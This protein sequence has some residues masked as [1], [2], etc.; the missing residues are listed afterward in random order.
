M[1]PNAREAL[2]TLLTDRTEEPP[3]ELLFWILV[4][5]GL[6]GGETATESDG[7]IAVG[8]PP[9]F[10]ALRGAR[11]QLD[12]AQFAKLTLS[13]GQIRWRTKGDT[14]LALNFLPD[15]LW[16]MILLV[17]GLSRCPWS[18]FSGQLGWSLK[19]YIGLAAVLVRAAYVYG[20][21][22]GK[23]LAATALHPAEQRM[24]KRLEVRHA[25][26]LLD[27]HAAKQKEEYRGLEERVL[28]EIVAIFKS[29]PPLETR[30][31]LSRA[32]KHYLESPVY[33]AIR[34]WI[35]AGAEEEGWG[36]EADA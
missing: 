27:E 32:A 10:E 11:N 31:S 7:G 5:D 14:A 2:R 19:T 21:V 25:L 13:P 29:D 8:W 24:M 23:V 3:F 20:L 16:A 6:D 36:R 22:L 12:G 17:E 26:D 35:L 4:Q 15:Q 30:D 33:T 34:D 18:S 28:D 1:V 9:L